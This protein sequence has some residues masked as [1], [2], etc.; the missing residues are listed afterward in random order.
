M[1]NRRGVRVAA[2][3]PVRDRVQTKSMAVTSNKQKEKSGSD[4]SRSV[5]GI[6]LRAPFRLPPVRTTKLH[7]REVNK[8]V[9][10]IRGS[11]FHT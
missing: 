3:C 5:S 4:G 9:W 11:A 1:N 10:F 2:T 7:K 8:R 6:C